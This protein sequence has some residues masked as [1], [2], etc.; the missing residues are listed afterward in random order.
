MAV[1]GLVL[2]VAEVWGK[3]LRGKWNGKLVLHESSS[4]KRS[5]FRSKLSFNSRFVYVIRFTLR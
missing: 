2:D 3:E 4:G 5:L 1:A